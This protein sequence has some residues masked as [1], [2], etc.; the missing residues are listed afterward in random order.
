MVGRGHLATMRSVLFRAELDDYLQRGVS[1]FEIDQPDLKAF[2]TTYGDGRWVMFHDD[3]ERDHDA[4][5]SAI[6]R[7]TS[8]PDLPVDLITIGRWD[9]S[10]SVA[11]RFSSGR[12][13]LAGDAAHTL[14]PSRGGFGVNTGIADAHSFAW[15]LASVR[16]GASGPQLLDSYMQERRPVAWR[17]HQ[18]ILARPDYRR[19]AEGHAADEPIIDD[20]AMEFGQ[21]YRFDVIAGGDGDLPDARRPADW[22]GQPGTRAPHLWVTCEGERISTLDLF[23]PG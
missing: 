19:R 1:Q 3:Q 20:T 17:R 16:S 10:A 15:E 22:A 2:L 5:R 21:I 14:S 8:R 12:V 13:F 11:E 23:Q 18:Q 6:A 9:L 7:A 4:L